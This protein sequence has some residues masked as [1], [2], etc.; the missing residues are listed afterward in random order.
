MTL[1]LEDRGRNRQ[2]RLLNWRLAAGCLPGLLLNSN[3]RRL[4]AEMRGLCRRLPALLQPSLEQGLSQLG[5]SVQEEPIEADEVTTRQ[6][7][8]L[9]ALLERGSPLGLC[10]RRSLIRY[11][12]LRRLGVPVMVNFGAK[13]VDGKVDRKIAGHAWLSLQGNPYHEEDANWRG[14]TVMFTWP[15]ER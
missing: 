8:D 11:H 1:A 6:L 14:F 4:L 10:L 12:F 5:D 15:K 2:A 9:A 7:A 13:L 3:H